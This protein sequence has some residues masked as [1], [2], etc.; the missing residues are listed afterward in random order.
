MLDMSRAG[1]ATMAGGGND[2]G[3]LLGALVGLGEGA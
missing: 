2:V 3:A 1:Y